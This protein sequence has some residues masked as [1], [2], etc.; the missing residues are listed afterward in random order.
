MYQAAAGAVQDAM[1]LGF[2]QTQ[3]VDAARYGVE[4][5]LIRHYQEFVL[6]P[7]VHDPFIVAGVQSV[8]ADANSEFLT[9]LANQDDQLQAFIRDKAVF[10]EPLAADSVDVKIDWDSQK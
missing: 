1:R 3:I 10:T 9:V 7:E 2:S 6:K 8:F 4:D 5:Y